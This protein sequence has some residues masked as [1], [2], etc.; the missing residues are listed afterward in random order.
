MFRV[1]YHVYF[2]S[3]RGLFHCPVKLNTQKGQIFCAVYLA[4]ALL[5]RS[6]NTNSRIIVSAV[7]RS[8]GKIAR[9][10][11]YFRGFHTVFGP[12]G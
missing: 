4:N 9:H 11:F 6:E 12:A 7:N 8:A 3:V 5:T 1:I 10:C 2:Y